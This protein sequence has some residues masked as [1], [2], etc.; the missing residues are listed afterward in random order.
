MGLFVLCMMFKLFKPSF[1]G[2]LQ[3]AHHLRPA[4]RPP[5]ACTPTTRTS[6]QWSGAGRG[7]TLSVCNYLHPDQSLRAGPEDTMSERQRESV[8]L[9]LGDKVRFHRSCKA[10]EKEIFFSEMKK[11]GKCSV[12]V[13]YLH[14]YQANSNSKPL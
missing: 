6:P 2:Q 13:F 1:C 7:Q 9:G 4:C 12:G 14:T 11:K 10:T 5:G 3:L 8:S